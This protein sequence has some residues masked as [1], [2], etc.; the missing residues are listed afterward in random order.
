VS[1]AQDA[2]LV[3]GPPRLLEP[4]TLR[5]GLFAEFV[6]REVVRAMLALAALSLVCGTVYLAYRASQE[7]H[8]D[9]A[10][11]WLQ[12]VLPAETG[13]LGSVLGFYFGSQQSER[14]RRG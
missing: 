3:V 14:L 1:Q 7:H 11:Q 12:V 5:T 2:D 9:S 6:G 8:W 4:H 10:K 13:I